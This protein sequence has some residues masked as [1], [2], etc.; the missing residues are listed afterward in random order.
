MESRFLRNVLIKALMLF[1][2]LNLALAAAYPLE[3]LGSL[4][5]YN[6]L[7]TGRERFPF[8]ENPRETY[9]FSLFNL[10][11]MLYS[12]RLH[13]QPKG[14][15][16][17]RVLVLG[18][19]S[20]W[21][22]LL[23][24]E[25]TLAGQL[26]RL[27]LTHCDGRRVRAYNLGYPTLS[28]V[29][30]VMILDAAMRYQPDWI[31]WGVT[32]QSF[33]LDRQVVSPIVANNPARVGALAQKYG[34]GIAAGLPLPDFWQRTLLGQRRALADWLRLQL[35]GFLWSATGIDQA[36]PT[37]YQPAVR[38]LENDPAFN[39]W[40]GPDF[41]PD[42]LA[43]EALDAGIQAAGATPLLLVNEPVMISSGLNSHV[44]YN[45]Y[46]PRWA[47]DSY[48]QRLAHLSG[49][50]GWAYLD[51]WDMAGEDEFTN[52]AIHLKP[53]AVKRMAQAVAA[54]LCVQP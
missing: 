23:Q 29:K 38:D 24:P 35:Y 53:A 47:Y 6:R 26:N 27:N 8:G 43:W 31:V 25:E 50:N 42:S 18:D 37:D 13:G 12:L 11:A 28:L 33:P 40:Q 22:T 48:R 51:L 30:D 15:D 5:L 10:E 49:A 9:S 44:R 32:L 41:P 7:F 52:S 46:Y 34:L 45:Y 36:Y 3:W 39:G 19:S 17:F 2:A 1:L 16:E 21:G 54:Q 14:A 4:S 20:I